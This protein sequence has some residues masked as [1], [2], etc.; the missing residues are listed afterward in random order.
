MTKH[1]LFGDKDP[2]DTDVD[3]DFP[4]EVATSP[5]DSEF[6]QL[7]STETSQNFKRMRRGDR[8]VAKVLAVGPSLVYFDI[9]QRSEGYAEKQFF[10][11][12]DLDTLIPGAE[13]PLYVSSTDNGIEL[14]K[15]LSA[16]Q[17]S[18]EALQAAYQNGLPV[19]GKV[20]G[21]NKG[22][23]TVE[24]SGMKGFVPFSQ[25]EFGKAK[26]ADEYIGKTFEFQ[27]TR[28]QGREVVLSRSAL[29]REE[30]EAQRQKILNQL[31][32]GQ[33][34]LCKVTKIEEFGAFIDLGGG[35][36]ALIPRSEIGWSRT[37]SV[38]EAVKVGEEVHVK[39][40]KIDRTGPKLKIA[41][42]MKQMEGD[43]WDI[44]ADKL[45][46]GQTV[47]G[48]P[49]RLVPFGAF[50][51][52]APGVEGLL[53]ISEMSSKKRIAQP[54]EVVS[55]GTSVQVR[56]TS[57]DRIQRRIGLSMKSLDD[58]TLDAE[59]KAKY[60]KKQEDENLHRGVEF[61]DTAVGTSNAFGDAFA[62]AKKKK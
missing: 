12:E 16:Q 7:L 38:A 50:V 55:V 31:E 20:T 34:H 22:G 59:T 18:S 25:M 8:V 13:I 21:E 47:S 2:F 46:V 30:N 6:A 44:T 40:I 48:S 10:S 39:I 1:R 23:F 26:P 27:I 42:S 17:A 33:Q 35:L 60:L 14:V 58:D 62:R 49:T 56:I 9:G 45:S 43:P 19:S 29:I 41:A 57:I 4:D 52:I 15:S 51:E 36:N 37:A 28:F 32:E 5:T 3:A 53:H 11:P 54:G 24:I 61:V